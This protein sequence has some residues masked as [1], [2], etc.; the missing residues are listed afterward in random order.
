MKVNNPINKQ[1][2]L[3]NDEL[4][5]KIIP[6]INIDTVNSGEVERMC[7]KNIEILTTKY[8]INR[9]KLKEIIHGTKTEGPH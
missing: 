9:D 1:I 4:F 6:L 5:K 2:I 3:D 7:E 8:N